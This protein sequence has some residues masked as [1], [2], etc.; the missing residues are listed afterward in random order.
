MADKESKLTYDPDADV[1]AWEMNDLSIVYAR[2]IR[3]VIVHFSSHH[4]PVLVEVLEATHFL[5]KA[6]DLSRI[7][8]ELGVVSSSASR[9]R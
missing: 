3:G 6:K 5:A 1:L 9:A 7:L 2:E 4:I 8:R